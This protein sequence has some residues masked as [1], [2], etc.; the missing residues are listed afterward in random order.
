METVEPLAGTNVREKNIV[1]SEKSTGLTGKLRILGSDEGKLKTELANKTLNL[2]LFKDVAKKRK[3][4]VDYARN[5]KARCQRR[6]TPRE[7]FLHAH[8]EQHQSHF[9]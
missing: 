9:Q 8:V 5:M 2:P 7:L 6:T 3:I 4:S 1:I